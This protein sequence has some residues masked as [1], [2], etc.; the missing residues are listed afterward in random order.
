M[1]DWAQAEQVLRTLGWFPGRH[2]D[3]V[4]GWEDEL[5]AKGGFLMHDAA[6]AFLREFGGLALRKKPLRPG[7]KALVFNI[8]PTVAIGEN[9]RFDAASIEAGDTLYPV[10]EAVNGHE[11]SAVEAKGDI[12]LVMDMVHHIAATAREGFARLAAH[13]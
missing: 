10:G 7:Y 3:R 13:G 2:D 1:G 4:N 5:T 6:R 9:D 11:F 12:Y 8:D